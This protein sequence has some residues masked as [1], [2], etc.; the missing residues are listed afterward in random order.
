M[1]ARGLGAGPHAGG[2]IYNFSSLLGKALGGYVGAQE[3]AHA[4]QAFADR[5][6][7][8]P[9]PKKPEVEKKSALDEFFLKEA[10]GFGAKS[11][12]TMMRQQALNDA[13]RA[14][15]RQGPQMPVARQ[16][17]MVQMA[18]QS[19]GRNIALPGANAPSLELDMTP[20]QFAYGYKGG[21]EKQAFTLFDL[22]SHGVMGA[23]WGNATSNPEH[24]LLGT[25]LGALGG[26]GGMVGGALT[27]TIPG[28]GTPSI[29]ANAMRP[30]AGAVAG[31]A[32]GGAA[33][34][35]LP[36]HEEEKGA[37]DA[38]ASFGLQKEAIAPLLGLAARA[39]PWMA[40][41]AVPWLAKNL[42]KGALVNGGIS[43]GTSLAQGQGVGQSLASGVVGA[44]AGMI[45]NPVLSAG[46]NMAGGMAVDKLMGPKASMGNGLN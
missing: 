38:S 26:M 45:K 33:T 13:F 20:K 36:R 16:V 23:A 40:R 43:A 7:P 5:N 19:G 42:G 28:N 22:I 10:A 32:L 17:P 27:P 46:A 14:A 30:V 44:G 21:S 8:K 37:A 41:T 12:G 29:I 1:L 35:L 25:T 24:Q 18:Q 2:N 15:P 31:G 4:G 3:G 6:K 9:E 34:R 11:M 39:V